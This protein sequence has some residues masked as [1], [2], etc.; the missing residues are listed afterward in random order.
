MYRSEQKSIVAVMFIS[1]IGHIGFVLTF[2]F[3]SLSV[4]PIDNVPSA[5]T[6][7][8]IAPVGA[9]IQAGVPIPAGM[10]VGEEIYGRLYALVNKKSAEAAL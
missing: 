8:L 2:Y 6:H 1:W 3:S 4:N 5:S 10:G 7:F 9:I